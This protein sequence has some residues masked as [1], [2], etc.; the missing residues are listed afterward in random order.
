MPCSKYKSKKQRAL[1][2]LTKEWT[3]FSKVSSKKMIQ[4]L[5]SKRVRN[6]DL[7]IKKRKKK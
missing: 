5:Q 6:I 2:Y 7:K 3:D 1:C 4:R